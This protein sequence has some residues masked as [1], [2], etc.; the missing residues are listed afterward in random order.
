VEVEFFD[1]L[2]HGRDLPLA[3]ARP[4]AKGLVQPVAEIDAVRFRIYPDRIQQQVLKR[5]IGAQRYI[6]NQKVEE[7]GYQLWLKK[8]AKF[9]NR[10]MEPDENYCPWDQ[11][12][13]QY[14]ESAPWLEEIPSFIRRNGCSRFRSAMAKWGKGGGRPQRKTRKS[15]RSVLLTSECFTLRLCDGQ[16]SLFIGTKSNNLGVLK[17]VRHCEY[18]EP[19]QISITH[20]PDGKWFVGFSFES[21]R[22]LPQTAI[23]ERKVEVLGLDRGVV[24]PVT[25]STGRF[26]DFTP[27]EEVKLGR[28]EKKRT[29]LQVRLAHQKKGSRRGAK[30]RKSIAIT[31]ARD[32]RLRASVAHRIAN[33]VVSHAIEAG[34]KAIALE[35]LQLG[36]MTRTCKAKQDNEGNY[37]PNGQAAKSGLNRSLLG[38][39]LGQIKTFLEYRCRR[40]G[41]IF[42]GVDPAG[43]SI[44]CTECHHKDKRSRL[45][46]A[47]FECV[48]CCHAEHA[49]VVGGTNVRDRAF[50]KITEIS[51]GTSLKNARL[52]KARKGQ[53]AR[54]CMSHGIPQKHA[55]H[56]GSII[57]ISGP[58]CSTA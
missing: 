30:T 51:P 33:H 38:R 12:Y 3:R 13:A 57:R 49:D 34:C 11:T 19:R 1:K 2:T 10:F 55:V 37:M 32:R 26:Y 5:W 28:R 21:G 22:V 35:D 17:W 41:L 54:A 6:Y 40:A 44:E 53:P 8:N 45:S 56:G 27:A 14:A 48:R 23:P 43:T 42:I 46:Q 47:E 24:N 39:A 9:S 31:H 52:S 50:K 4:A 15:V 7:L 20:E 58:K 29:K 36:N 18:K 16:D 25:D